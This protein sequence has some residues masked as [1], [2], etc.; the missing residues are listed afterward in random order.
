MHFPQHHYNNHV[1]I[2][3][4]KKMRWFFM[5]LLYKLNNYRLDIRLIILNLYIY[6]KK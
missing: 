3:I 6:G 4:I 1:K 5:F 2:E